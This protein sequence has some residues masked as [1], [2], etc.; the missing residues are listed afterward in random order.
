M[1]DNLYFISDAHLGVDLEGRKER[2]PALVRFLE[3][4]QDHAAQLFIV[5]E[6]FEFWFEYKHLVPKGHVE[7]LSQLRRMVCSGTQVH[8]IVGN[9]DFALGPFL[10]KDIGINLHWRPLHL[11]FQGKR[12]FVAHG[13]GLNKRDLGYR[14]LKVV[15]RSKVSQALYRLLP[16]DFAMMLAQRAADLSR[17]ATRKRNREG[18]AMAY[19]SVAFELLDAGFDYVVMG[20]T[21]YAEAQAHGKGLYINVSGWLDSYPYAEFSAGVL[22]LKYFK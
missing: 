16:P 22:S 2:E 11:E 20:H 13:D 10:E 8:Y 7:L 3:S 9:H 1:K 15:L 6:L 4:I 21:H 5:G 12:F 18:V 17:S 19:R 14:I